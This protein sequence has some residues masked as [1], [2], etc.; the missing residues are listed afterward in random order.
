LSNIRNCAAVTAA[1]SIVSKAKFNKVGGF[2]EK[3]RI[4]Y[5][6]VDLCLRLLKAGYRNVYTP[7]SQLYHFESQ[8]IGRINT[9]DRDHS[10]IEDAKALMRERWGEL[11]KRDP[12]YN[13]NFLPYGD[14]YR[15][16]E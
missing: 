8:S 15:L 16:T 1:C 3:L 6:D 14:G 7:Y 12:Y 11:L 9:G 13:E 4:T 2:D 10:E 5:N